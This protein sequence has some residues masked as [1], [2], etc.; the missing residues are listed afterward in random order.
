[1]VDFRPETQFPEEKYPLPSSR[2]GTDLE[3]NVKDAP[4]LGEGL[5]GVGIRVGVILVGALSLLPLADWIPG[6][7]GTNLPLPFFP[8]FLL[9][10]FGLVVVVGL[11]W[12]LAKL[13][14]VGKPKTSPQTDSGS[15]TWLGSLVVVALLLILP[16]LLYSIVAREVFDGRPLHIDALTQALQAQIF[17]QGRLSVPAPQ[18]PGFFSTLL[19]TEWDGRSF[20]QFPPG[21]AA[22]LT[23]GFLLGVPWIVAPLCAALGVWGLF[24]LLRANGERG[25]T[26]LL[27]ALLF[28]VTPWIVFN[29]ASWM[30]H[31][32]TVSFIILGSAALLRGIRQPASWLFPGLG[33]ACL[34]VATL[35]RPLEG[36]AFGIPATVWMVARAWRLP[37]ARRG[38]AAFATGGAMTVGLLLAYNWVQHGSPLTFGFEVQWGSAHALGFHE[39]PWGPPHTFLRGVQLLN[40]YFLALQLLFFD[41][42]APSLVP[43]LAALLLVRRFDALDRYLLAGCGLVLLGYLSFWGEGHYLGPR[44]LL[45][46]APIIAIWTVRFGRVVGERVGRVGARRWAH[47]G[48]F[49]LVLGGWV[50]GMPARWVMYRESY[51]L[52]RLELGALATPQAEGALIFVPSPWSSQV[53]ARLRA[54][55]LSRPEAQWFH[56][57]IGLCRIDLALLDLKRRGI[58]DPRE[59]A[60][61]LRPL[62]ADS[63]SMVRNPLSG[64]PGDVFSGMGA[65]DERDVELCRLRQSLQETQ[66]GFLMLPFYAFLGPTWTGDGPILARDLYE[67]NARLLSAHP[68]R[69]VFVLRQ[70]RGRGRVRALRLE[71]LRVDSAQA[72]WSAF[73]EQEQDSDSDGYESGT[74][75]G[76]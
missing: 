11:S 73:G 46:L 69:E 35:I 75:T 26:A 45:P 64:A 71:P 32:P 61:E 68:D 58:S 54:T 27:T 39:A 41:S 38:L 51:P 28:A 5:S 12:V 13:I 8:L 16:T 1:M 3:T 4:G 33:A 63:T 31:L 25:G 10:S 20:S 42:P 48:V 76:Y 55:D 62:A 60:R 74:E 44:Y 52:R 22:F 2:I 30:S 17:G 6:P 24:L 37:S 65:A 70:V 56:D 66:G 34:G 59:I 18:D 57:R 21:W 40:D 72:V 14:P 29:G 15:R 47:A 23:L 19:V 49:L 67:E 53:Q 50:F 7:P 43:A 9:W 36:V